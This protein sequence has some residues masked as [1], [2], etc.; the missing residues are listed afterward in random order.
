MAET[1]G[2]NYMIT[3]A[4]NGLGLEATKQLALLPETK[5]VYMACRTESKALAAIQGLV[6]DEGVPEEKLQ[7]VHFD[8]C[9]SK[10]SIETVVVHLPEKEPI[11]GLILNAGGMVRYNQN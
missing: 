7:Y 3:G 1:T 5:K 9:S 10:V 2:K 8:A 6:N 4:N 11:H